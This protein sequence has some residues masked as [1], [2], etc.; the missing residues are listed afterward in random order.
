MNRADFVQPPCVCGECVQAGVS[1]L[2][3]IREYQTGKFL[4]G[5]DLKR[6][7]AAR[8]QFYDVMAAAQ[9]KQ[10]GAVAVRLS[11]EPGEEG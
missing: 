9:I 4:H 11:R 10:F 7:Y 8:Q 6:W 5:Y 3:Q 2:E 1:G